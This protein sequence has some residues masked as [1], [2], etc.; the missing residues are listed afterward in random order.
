[1]GATYSLSGLGENRTVTAVRVNRSS[2]RVLVRFHHNGREE[3]VSSSRLI[4]SRGESFADD[5]G[6]AAIWGLL[7]A[8]LLSGMADDSSS[9]RSNSNSFDASR[10]SVDGLTAECRRLYNEWIEAAGGRRYSSFAISRTGCGWAAN[11]DTESGADERAIQEC[12]GRSQ[13]CVVR[14][15]YD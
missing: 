8:G 4:R 5:A 2:G 13:G 12:G 14:W 9:S 15:T 7:I 11:Y 6:E 1:V 3:W 10:V